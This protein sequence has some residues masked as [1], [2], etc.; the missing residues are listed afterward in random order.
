MS[1][2]D[3]TACGT[4]NEDDAR[5][6]EGCGSAL[7]RTCGA[8]GVTVSA[9]ARFCKSCG[10]SLDA[11]LQ[12]AAEG[13]TRKTVT[14]M[15]A[16]LAGS[17]A[18]E[19]IVDAETAREVIGRYHELLRSTVER[20]RVG[21]TKY[22]GDG[23]MAVWGVPEIG[24]D[25][26]GRAVDAAIE[27]QEH[28]VGLALQVAEAHGVELALRVAVNTGEVVV[29]ADDADLVGDA[30]NVGARLESECPHGQVVVGEETW[31]STRGQ[32]RYEPLG[33]VRVKGRQ[34][35]V[36]VYRWLG[37]R[38][39]AAE[40]ISFV[41]RGDELQRLRR[42]FDNAVTA[43]AARL[44][45][46][47]GDPGVG[48]TRL[49][50]EF[51]GSLP[52]AQVIEVRCAVEGSPALA[53]VVEVLRPLDLESEI[54][55]GTAERDRML[56]DLTGMTAGVPGSVE[57]T[58]WALRRFVEVLASGN[59]VV[60]VLDD[61]Q[62]ADSLLLD[63]IEH[64]AEWVRGVPVLMLALARP[65]L[66]ETRPDLVT[67]G[68]WVTE[69]VRL[70]GLEAD[71]TAE[72]AGRVLGSDRLPEELLR[73][74]P[75]STG[76]NP[77]FVRELVGML[78]H[79][80]VLAAK[81]DGWRLTVDA[82]D[83]D[84]PPTIHALLASRLERLKPADRRV[85]EVASVIGTDFTGSGVTELSGLRSTEI[86]SA[87]NRLR[88]LDLAQPSGTY[89]G[90]EAVWRFHHVLIRDVAYRRLLKSERADLHE[91]LAN[92]VE[93]GGTN[94]A[95][96]SDEVVARNL[97]A[98]QGYRADLGL[99]DAHGAELALRSAR[100][101]LSSA[102]RALDRDELVSAGTQAA[103]GAGLAVADTAL[104]AELLL[105][106]CE[107][108]LSAGDVAAGSPLVDDLERIAGEALAPW[109]ICYRCQL[110]VYTDPSRLP[111]AD[112][113]LQEAIDEFAQRG[114]AAGLAKA[115][116]V[117]AN[118]RARLGRVGDAE[119]D[120]FEALIAA[121]RGGDHRQITAAL[122]AAPNAALWGPS[123]APKA[124]GR[125]LDVVRMQRMT[126][127]APSLEATSLRCLAV[128]ELLRGRPDKARTMLA[129]ARQVVAELGLRH[130]LMETE[131]YAGIIELMVGDPVAAEP[132]FRTA[133]EGLDALGVGADA[134]QAAALLA[135]SVLAQGRVEEADRYAAE[136]ERIAGHNL[137]TAIGWRA[138]R[139]EILSA[140]DQHEAAV[141]KAREA[142]AVA[143]DTDLVLDH[144][145]ACLALSRVLDAAGDAS[146]AARARSDA[147]SLYAAK[148]AVFM[149]GRTAQAV[150]AAPTSAPERVTKHSRLVVRNRASEVAEA[151]W[152]AFRAHDVEAV[153]A[154]FSDHTV[155]DDRRSIRGG[156][157][158]GAGWWLKA[159][160]RAIAD[161]PNAEWQFVAVRG[162]TVALMRARMWD[163]A[164]NE[165]VTYTVFELDAGALIGYYGR[166]DGDDFAG[167]Y[168]EMEARY[169]A[170][171][172]AE[173]AEIG[174]AASAWVEAMW[175][176]DV[177]AARRI[178]W[179]HFRWLASP[180]AIKPEERSVDDFFEWLGERKSQL[181]AMPMWA[182]T[183]H[184]MSPDC[185]VTLTE[186]QGVG[187]DGEEYDWS[188]IYAIEYRDGLALS[189]R[190][191]NVDDEDAAFVY[192][193]SLVAP[194]TSRLAVDNAASR[195]IDRAIKGLRANDS[196]AINAVFSPRIV[197]EDR[198]PLAGALITGIDYLSE[199]VV[200]LL[201]QYDHFTGGALAVRGDRICLAWSR[202]SDDTGNESSNLH[203]I[204]LGEDGL[205][206]RYLYCD[207]HDFEDA[208]REMEAWYY[209]GEGA[210]Y[211]ENGRTQSAFVEAMNHLDSAGI[212]Q[213]CRPEFRWLSIPSTLTAP[214]RSVDELIEWWRERTEQTGSVQNWNSAI[215]WLSPEVWVGNGDARGTSMDGAEYTWAGVY[216]GT[217]AGGLVRSVREF[218]DD[219]AAFA[220]AESLVDQKQQRLMVAN[221]ASRVAD[222]LLQAFRAEDVDAALQEFSANITYEERRALAGG[223]LVGI[224]YLRE[225][226]PA[227]LT[228]YN[229]FDGQ[230][231]AVRGE[232]LCLTQ[233][234]WWDDSGNTAAN[235]H[236]GE[237]DEDGRLRHLLYFDAEDFASAYG[238]LDARYYAGE[239][240][241]YVA[242]GRTQSAF[243][244]A[245][246]HLDVEAARQLCR[247][248]FRWSSPTRALAA[249]VRT[250]D[251]VVSWWR[252]RA[253]QVD[254]LWNW[255]SA[256]TW[257]TRDVAVSMGEARGTI[258]DGADYS[259]SGIFVASFRDGL[260]E[261]VDG[262]EPEDE[263]VAFAYAQSLVK[264]RN[265]RLVAANAASRALDQAFAAMRADDPGAVAR[266]F[267]AAVVY[268]DRRPLA[269]ALR[270]G[271]DYLNEVVPELLGQY[272]HFKTRIL[273]VR[274]ERL[275][276]AW[277][278][279][280]DESGNE[281]TN[282][283][284][285]ELGG[286][287]TIVHLLYFVEEDFWSA[288]REMETRYFD[289][290]GAPYAAGGRAA[291]DWV[292]AI[293]NGDLEGV[294]RVSHPDFRWY[295][296]PS[297][298]KEPER[299]VDDMFRWWQERGRQVSSQRHWVPA[300]QWLSPNCAV[301][302][303]EIAAVGPDG[304][305]YN[306]NL[307]HVCECRDGLVLAVR[308]FD[309]ED[310]AFAY[311]ESVVAP[312]HS[313]L[314]IRNASS[315]VAHR[316]LVA[317]QA[318]D[319]DTIADA[320][321]EHYVHADH[322]RLGG[323]PIT[324]RASA[325][326]AWE[327]IAQLYSKFEI[328][329][330][331]VRGERL[332]LLR[333]RWSDNAGNQS[334]GLALTEASDGL[335]VFQDR[336]D[337]GD[338]GAAYAALEHRYYAGEGASYAAE[339]TTVVEMV[340]AENRG[341]LDGAFSVF[342]RPGLQIENRSRSVFPTR[343]A[344]EL[345]RSVEA[346]GAMV[347]SYR[348]WSP[349]YCWLSP[350][351]VVARHEREA[352]GDNGETYRWSRLYAG[353]IRGGL[354]TSLCE[355]DADDEDAAFAYAVERMRTFTSRLTLNNRA[356]EVGFDVI[357]A[358]QT[359]DIDA[360]VA[361]YS[362]Q[363]VYE[364]RRRLGGDP[365]IGAA[366]VRAAISRLCDQY[367]GFQMQTLAVRGDR[368]HLAKHIWS[369]DAGNESHGLMLVE[370]DEEGRAI[371]HGSFDEDD[372]IGAFV[373]LEKRYYSGEGAAFAESGKTANEVMV[374][375]NKV[376]LDKLFGELAAPGLRVESRSGTI[377]PD[378]TTGELRDSVELFHAMV[379]SSQTWYSAVEWLTPQCVV[380]RQ[381]RRAVGKDGERYEWSRIYV[382]EFDHGLFTAICDFDTDF[383]EQAF[384]YAEQRLRA[385][386]NRIAVRNRA[387]EAAER[388]TSALRAAD[389]GA[390]LSCCSESYFLDDRR[391][392]SGD[393]LRGVEALR[394]GTERV[395]Q[396]FNAFETHPLAVRGE[397]FALCLLRW[398]DESGNE[399]AH[400]HVFEVGHDGRIAYEVRFDE[401][402]F[403]SAHRELESRY[404]AGEG[405][406]FA[407]YGLFAAEYVATMNR[408]DFDTMFNELS[409]PG[410][411]FE[412]RGRSPF[413]N[414]SARELRA[415]FEDLYARLASVRSWFSSLHWVSPAT[416]VGRLER[417]GVG[418]DSERYAWTRILVNQYRE[419]RLA[420][421]CEF[422]P[423]D[424]AAALAYAEELAGQ[425]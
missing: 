170:G 407:Q 48:K 284:V 413:P 349:A 406:A 340:L 286:D 139:A 272:K 293:S 311:A 22:I 370:V 20:H 390:L 346:L 341:D 347:T 273:A 211:A 319:F 38:T 306:W 421:T 275:C 106:G 337:E 169:Y 129:D 124:G 100:S 392:F 228:Q 355:F 326:A 274:G 73:R 64:L 344:A 159:A 397:R 299:T 192:A 53:P 167:A 204:E 381:E 87:L 2:R 330:L 115:H 194:K 93:A 333:Y 309:D 198:R 304:Q 268:E 71:A 263:D 213:L 423:G 380:T 239:G 101:Y 245:M 14:V 276:L 251:E 160:E 181:S 296:T 99:R 49:A 118:A 203:M 236:V 51:A 110:I 218:D 318:G 134:G 388:V 246:D 37:H 8:C 131:L 142:V 405:A 297:A 307:I 13:P 258:G 202:W 146:G 331:A 90:D 60:V 137:K 285:T 55:A 6:C 314:A 17:T 214:E 151:G 24:A 322:R 208:Y 368:L 74:L 389:V 291:V 321:A 61:I 18:F 324:N 172:G 289:D 279:W 125:C 187:S 57:E 250:I 393:T 84:V 164:G 377:F 292:T 161:Y 77:L 302:L 364:D 63:F 45:T 376:D 128:L 67:V 241:A 267:S 422:D 11:E 66:R 184:W 163:D 360:A 52:G 409:S 244:A 94:L 136:S 15:F 34:A 97:E 384:A 54:P 196:D 234:R 342:L 96:E 103:R 332:H 25:D 294:R 44:V 401:D 295:A 254:S 217:F 391:R 190:E 356:S 171:E 41:G 300:V 173:C 28:F 301:G 180:S 329:I 256:I 253:E 206:A 126:T 185:F 408:G 195:V 365:I 387:S 78:V 116:R 287:G 143:A 255:T 221:A 132:H 235:L 215:K 105:V 308:E 111:E 127:A 10:A 320:Y 186:I 419:G 325:R 338:F 120:L 222:R 383:E 23:F 178:S 315:D 156:P 379:S 31:R 243:V 220:Y 352:V 260:F 230:T 39:D 21:L 259:W 375:G 411:C 183:I 410:F 207:G 98:A 371:Y 398:S 288:Y 152:L 262:F 130:G 123:P 335:I 62:W 82:D 353:E 91:R 150:T 89:A 261:S 148:D 154:V 280:S 188:R 281:A 133:L 277:S 19:E 249:P 175:R 80:G 70:R 269:G 224:D 233:S 336:F 216:V 26:A 382:A 153:G 310:S 113:R 166:F 162:D 351:W 5:F 32:H 177:E 223:L 210:A 414:R 149:V 417:E 219:D 108:F 282:L 65:E 415:S 114:D 265:S 270:E 424:E 402:D 372:F 278:R 86:T 29:G 158:A 145:D 68:G 85:L 122:G 50:A 334:I 56:R 339:K 283:H 209:A 201:A 107:A 403:E 117:R 3:C 328:D 138:V 144:A 102:R 229:H 400:L 141:A 248:E 374:A 369:D 354:F 373:E 12:P 367:N 176:C 35:P 242:H 264:Q 4:A 420:S 266:L 350:N 404:Y 165:S 232:R 46:V 313:R 412:N 238:E 316:M 237:L 72:L 30:L 47:T 179:P 199:S 197:Y 43:R 312:T 36:S 345:R 418:H 104:H 366:G 69:A 357:R 323:G 81:P 305:K 83:I 33:A 225:S 191:F 363:V 121:R 395:L 257:L 58:F 226:V 92:W 109:A 193:E 212:R 76:G 182:A 358:A 157:L 189:V 378:R 59:P 95:F 343:T 227:L 119:I 140:Q 240:A 303:G 200:A 247:P 385:A 271:V 7:E 386:Q 40:T 112:E 79:D 88:R 231:L 16:D 75:T 9:T 359:R 298:L 27:L 1:T 174:R 252:D 416:S 394:A 396:H 348:V 327:K 135:R 168:R 205:I 42:V 361:A 290:E 147:E 362:D 317:L 425:T 399:S 155:Y